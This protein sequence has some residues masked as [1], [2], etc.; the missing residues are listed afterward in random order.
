M[1]LDIFSW[2]ILLDGRISQ[3]GSGEDVLISRTLLDA[4][5]DD[6]KV[7]E[8]VKILEKIL[9]KGLKAPKRCHIRID[10]GQCS[11]A[12]DVDRVKRL[13][14]EA[15]IKVGYLKNMA[16]QVGCV[17]DKETYGVLVDG[18]CREGKFLEASIVLEKM[19]VKSYWPCAETYNGLIEMSLLREDVYE[20]VMWLEE[21]A[22]QGKLPEHSAWNSFVACMC[23]QH[24]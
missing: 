6:W 13:V 19:L 23:H 24:G 18:L 4:L 9:R 22:S 20:A 10:L 8:A 21:M 3:K 15:V 11:N 14:N 12:E 7:E 5:C 16:K 1:A 17:A 2:R